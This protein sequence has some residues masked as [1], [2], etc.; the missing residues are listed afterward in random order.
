[1]LGRV[2]CL[3]FIPQKHLSDIRK[4]YLCDIYVVASNFYFKS[5]NLVIGCYIGERANTLHAR[6][7]SFRMGYESYSL[8]LKHIGSVVRACSWLILHITCL[9]KI[10]GQFGVC[11]VCTALVD[12][13][14]DNAVTPVSS[15]T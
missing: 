1:M 14:T 7:E 15:C 3:N 13:L 4:F 12:E 2:E 6:I 9:F 10:D 5:Y 8:M 11:H